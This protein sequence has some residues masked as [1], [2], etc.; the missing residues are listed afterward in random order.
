MMFGSGEGFDYVECVE[1]E[2]LQIKELPDLSRHY[3]EEY[4]SFKDVVTPK[5]TSALTRKLMP[6]F[7]AVNKRAQSVFPSVADRLGHLDLETQFFD[8][9]LGLSTV[10]MAGLSRGSRILDV[11]CGAGRLLSILSELGHESLTGIDVFLDRDRMLGDGVR[12]LKK[13]LKEIEGKYDL[14]MFHHS[15]EHLPEPE[16]ALSA[17]RKKLAD[18]GVCLVRI[19]VVNYAWEKYGV[20]WVGLDAPRHL[21]LFTEKGFCGLAERSGF[22]VERVVYDSTSFQ[23]IGSEQYRRNIPLTANIPG[24]SLFT[25]KQIREWKRK[26]RFL[27]RERRGDQAAFYLRP[28]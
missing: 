25:A 28:R 1:C 12:L 22:E 16:A 4:Y 21:H 24:S 5:R 11:G 3:P 18:G 13:E 26:A 2:T 6:V 20:N 10:M 7:Y 14:I 15:F 8:K 9:G 17:A 27:N 19:P 23:F